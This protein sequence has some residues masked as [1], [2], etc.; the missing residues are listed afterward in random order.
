MQGRADPRSAIGFTSASHFR[1]FE[2]CS[3]FAIS[4]TAL[5]NYCIEWS[6]C[7]SQKSDQIHGLSERKK[8]SVRITVTLTFV[9]AAGPA[10][11]LIVSALSLTRGNR[12]RHPE[13]LGINLP[14]LGN[15]YTVREKVRK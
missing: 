10:H 3:S 11:G 1:P 5:R 15:T 13:K 9:H 14:K 6:C 2:T 4:V 7:G 12:G 8:K